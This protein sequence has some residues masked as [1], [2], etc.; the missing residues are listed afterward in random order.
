MIKCR[1]MALAAIVL[2][3]CSN[4]ANMP[5]PSDVDD[6]AQAKQMLQSANICCTDFSTMTMQPLH[7]GTY[8]IGASASV[9]EFSTGRSAFLA[10]AIPSQYYGSEVTAASFIGKTVMPIQVI[11]LDEQRQVSR[12]LDDQAFPFSKATIFEPNSFKGKIKLLPNERFMVVYANT[13]HLEKSLS[14]P[15]PQALKQYS[16]G[17]ETSPYPD[18]KI[19]YSP[20]GLVSLKFEEP[21]TE[22]SVINTKS[23]IT[24]TSL[25]AAAPV[26]VAPVSVMPKQEAAPQTAAVTTSTTAISAQTK[27]YYQQAIQGAVKA[28]QLEQAMQLVSEAK[29]L[30]YSE[31][32]N[33][34]IQAV[35]AK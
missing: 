10:G 11:L 9:M 3:G 18:V 8:S 5:Q 24:S 33:V 34:F 14:L 2:T 22:T 4:F 25:A 7:N 30:G 23:V 29:K 32:Q 28:N 21:N 35:K 15:S 26:A 16:Q 19:P 1:Y 17:Y 20:W 12:S 31:A 13:S 27:A 6:S